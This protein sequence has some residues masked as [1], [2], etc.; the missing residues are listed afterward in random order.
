MRK[1][2]GLLALI[3]VAAPV[4]AA[5]DIEFGDGATLQGDL[6]VDD[7]TWVVIRFDEGASTGIT[8]VSE[9]R[10]VNTTIAD[11][12]QVFTPNAGV[13]GQQQSMNN[14]TSL[15]P[16]QLTLKARGPSSTLSLRLSNG[17][18][19]ILGADASL[20]VVD[21]SRPLR[22]WIG[23]DFS[24]HDWSPWMANV[25]A[26]PA[27]VLDALENGRL[28]L[29]NLEASAVEWY[30]MDADCLGPGFCPSGGGPE[31][32]PVSAASVTLRTTFFHYTR[33]EGPVT[34]SAVGP[35]IDLATGG[36]G[37]DAAV[38]GAIKLPSTQATA[39]DLT[40][41]TLLAKG[42]LRLNDIHQSGEGMSASLDGDLSAARLDETWVS[43]ESLG[44]F[45]TAAAAT[46][47]IGLILKL[48]VA[49]LFTRLSKKEA[50]E[51]PR[52]KAI[53][54]YVQLHPGA[55]FREVARKTGIAAGTVR[56][57]LTIL[58]RSGHLVEHAHNGTVRL[59]EN[60]G[61]FDHNWSDLVLLR[62]PSLAVVHDWLKVHP[63]SPQ[64]DILEA[65]EQLGWSRSTTQHRLARLADGGLVTIRLQGR[66]KI[67]SLAQRPAPKPGLAAVVAASQPSPVS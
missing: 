66:L 1:P 3:L 4:Q 16:V 54:E 55:N 22:A 65:M 46:V 13:E 57:H 42:D 24:Q 58:E 63:G 50:L 33:I 7:A 27:L 48:L 10:L 17:T 14:S 49:P 67:Y 64:K 47:G 15:A 51:H 41:Q 2:L 8:T 56:H 53:Y 36:N 31:S 5:L 30:N 39:A 25:P 43:P 20:R 40:D 52:R 18:S 38:F 19:P 21:P 26:G 61:K 37:M 45:G 12:G 34:A 9:T 28:N 32:V 60:H 62:E 11:V 23:D 35:A 59:F 44:Q 6:Q 29:S